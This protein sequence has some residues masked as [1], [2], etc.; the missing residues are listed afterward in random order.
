MREFDPSKIRVQI[1]LI[2]A[3]STAPVPADFAAQ[4]R[5][6][7]ERAGISRIEAVPPEPEPEGAKVAGEIIAIASFIVMVGDYYGKTE[8][9][10]KAL[11]QLQ[12][13]AVRTRRQ[14]RV[15]LA[16]R[17]I[18]LV[19][20]SPEQIV[21]NVR[22]RLGEA[23]TGVRKALIVA[24]S[25]FQDSKLARLRAPGKDA[26]ELRRVLGDPEIGAFEVELLK[27]A[28]ET[29]IRRRIDDFFA[30]REYDDLLLL[31]FSGH[32]VKDQ[33]GHLHLAARDSELRR[34]SSTAVPA[35]FIRDCMDA[36]ASQR[37]VLILD[38]CYSGAFPVGAQARG[39]TDVSVV[40]AFGVGSGHVV[41]TAS[42]ATEYAFEGDTL[43]QDAGQPSFFTGALVEGLETGNADLD[44]DGA[45][46]VNEL[47]DY[48]H[49]EVKRRSPA[50]APTKSGRVEGEMVIA[51]SSRVPQ[52]PEQLIDDVNSIHAVVRTQAVVQLRRLKE[53][54]SARFSSVATEMLVRLRDT[55]DSFTV[56]K[57]AAEALGE[58]A[59]QEPP[60]A[61]GS[62][63]L[64]PH[65]SNPQPMQYSPH[66]PAQFASVQEATA[67]LGP[68]SPQ[69]SSGSR[70]AGW[71]QVAA[72]IWMLVLTCA[73]TPLMSTETGSYNHVDAIG[74]A[75]I[76][77]FCPLLLAGVLLVTVPKRHGWRILGFI[78]VCVQ[79]AFG[80]LWVGVSLPHFLIGGLPIIG[81]SAF[82]AFL[83]VS[84]GD[85]K[86]VPG[87]PKT[88]IP[89]PPIGWP[90]AG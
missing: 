17:E 68:T 26:E 86:S 6:E 20:Q 16:G 31:H 70:I 50:Q 88:L 65:P 25:Q 4:A 18:D 54:T 28:N 34:L 49:R 43:T 15:R 53:G 44:S 60:P 12:S 73:S 78:G 48:L 89:P 30:D 57:A 69:A 27:D 56:R 42:S 67:P 80:M 11:R 13:I 22:S 52:F 36:S 79:G 62:P 21:A 41:L 63:Y 90:P 14:I 85:L 1:S 33:H 72:S 23:S 61:P 51:K 77:M 2:G 82:A 76:L 32:G 87:P 8:S 59:R 46:G 38:C 58:P 5:D 29:V 3:G 75:A 47:Y 45:I 66:P 10:V 84:R 9:F 64:P 81:A 37:I 55:D 74:I 39:G 83:F 35:K 19:N 71:V 7:I 24:N 40:D